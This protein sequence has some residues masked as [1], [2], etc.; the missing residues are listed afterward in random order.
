[1]RRL[2]EKLT[3]NTI[4]YQKDILTDDENYLDTQH[5]KRI[6][7]YL[8]VLISNSLKIGLKSLKFGPKWQYLY[9][10]PILSAIFV[11]IATVKLK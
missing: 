8:A 1:M 11:T 3:W 10:K 6:L 5:I 2:T 7:W 9:F 4:K